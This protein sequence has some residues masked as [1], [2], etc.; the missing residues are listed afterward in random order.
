[1]T[2]EE[3]FREELAYDRMPTLER[4]RPHPVSYA[5][6]T[7]PNDLQLSRRVPPCFSDKA[8]VFSVLMGCIPSAL[9]SFAVS[10]RNVNA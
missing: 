7:E 2:R 1:M 5:V 4:G 9:V 8:G 10:R 3:P 6:D